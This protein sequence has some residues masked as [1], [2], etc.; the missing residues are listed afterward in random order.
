MDTGDPLHFAIEASQIGS[1]YMK[2]TMSNFSIL[3]NIGSGGNHVRWLCLLDKRFN[4]EPAYPPIEIGSKTIK[5]FILQDVYADQRS[6]HNW[7]VWEWRW[8]NRLDSLDLIYLDHPSK[9]RIDQG[10][11]TDKDTGP[12]VCIIVSNDSAYRHYLK[13][14]TGLNGMSK[15]EFLDKNSELNALMKDKA[16]KNP[17][18]LIV[19]GASLFTPEIS[20]ISK[21]VEFFKLNI[22]IDDIRE[23]HDRWIY[24][25]KKAEIEFI[26][27]IKKLYEQ[28]SQ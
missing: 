20:E 4:I 3:A 6:W 13:F 27:D 28:N 26:N 7:L 17:Q 5:D 25:N 1:Q 14:N 19:D 24:L 9:R 18:V 22:P 12:T 16:K 21:I 10:L 8:R 23:V 15:Q 11:L 2:E